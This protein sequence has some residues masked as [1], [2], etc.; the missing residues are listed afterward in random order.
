MP[1]KITLVFMILLLCSTAFT[2]EKPQK[3]GDD[4]PVRIS[5][6]LIQLD[7]VVT[8]KSGRIVRGLNKEDFTLYDKGKKQEINFVDFVDAVA[9]RR[10]PGGVATGPDR[11][12]SPQGLSDADVRRIFAFVVDDLTIRHEDL[13]YLREMLSNFVEKQ[14]QPTDLVAIVRTAGGKGLLQQ[15]TNN[16][17]LLRQAINSLWYTNHPLRVFNNVEPGG[18]TAADLQPAGGGAGA[19][20]AAGAFDTTGGA[21]DIDHLQ[22]DSN[23][24][25]RAYMTLGTAS[26]IIE[27]LKQLPGR[28]SLVLISGGIP[29]LGARPN[30]SAG[31]ITHYLNGLSDKATRAGVAIHSL[32]LRGM[33][34][35][36]GVASFSQTEAKSALGA[37]AVGGFGRQPDESLLG[38]MNPL[39]TMEGHQGLRVLSSNTGGIAVL[40]KNDFNAALNRIV[41]ISEGYYLLAYTPSDAK[42]DGDF[43][44]LEVKVK[45]DYK[46]YNRRGYYAREDK[47]AAAPITKQEQVLAAVKS[48]LARR[49]IEFDAMVL[50]K[51]TQP[52]QAAIDIHLAIDPKKVA[53]EEQAGKQQA[54]LDV[55]VFVFD[56]LGKL[57]GGTSET[58]TVSLAPDDFK[59]AVEAGFTYSASTALPPGVYQVRVAVYDNKTQN[60]G[61]LSRYLEVPDL[62][63]GRLTA[64]SLLLGAVPQKEVKATTPSPLSATRQISRKSDLRYAVIIYNAKQKDGKPQVTT[65]LVVS[66]NG[67]PIFKEAEEPVQG[68]Q[69]NSGQL[70]KVGQLGMGGVKPGR[71]TLTLVITDPLADKKAQAITRSMDFVVVD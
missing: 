51:A 25:L 67:Q 53:F 63:K 52:K 61:T 58:V 56:E 18:V 9:G 31:D 38:Y 5:T 28:K 62:T 14:M 57:R 4:Q 48:P 49:D 36:A 33:Q 44:K 27:G 1:K 29:I 46:I 59:Q 37:G 55:V 24:L 10:T 35:H 64:S 42:F 30:S 66:Q 68:G 43:R 22:E 65:Q 50:Y 47:P 3:P 12:V 69:S 70:L 54:T 8:D 20:I 40:N 21:I 45:G 19:A 6:E 15:F 16:K 11:T 34:A 71:Y 13:S 17:D 26:F 23:K 60:I 32:D 41:D 39:D 2:Q 7:V